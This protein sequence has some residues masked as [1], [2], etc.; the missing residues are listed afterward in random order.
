MPEI[1]KRRRFK[2]YETGRIRNKLRHVVE[3]LSTGANRMAT[4]SDR[5]GGNES[6]GLLEERR[7]RL[8]VCIAIGIGSGTS[9]L[10]VSYKKMRAAD[11]ATK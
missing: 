9:A 4:A 5:T 3:R 10:C 6:E 2:I 7:L 11:T 1:I 8:T